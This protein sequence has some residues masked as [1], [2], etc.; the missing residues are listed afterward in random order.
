MLIKNRWCFLQKEKVSFREKNQFTL[1][2]KKSLSIN[3]N[4]KASGLHYI[5]VFFFLY[6]LNKRKKESVF[7]KEKS[8]HTKREKESEQHTQQKS[9]YITLH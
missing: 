2:E 7:Q 4:Q 6:T 8:I 9:K 1:K 5:K 3:H